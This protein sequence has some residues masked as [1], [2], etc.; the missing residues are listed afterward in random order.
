MCNPALLVADAIVTAGSGTFGA[1]NTFAVPV[2]VSGV[3][4]L[5]AYQFDLSYDPSAL[6]LLSINEGQLLQSAGSTFFIPGT[7]DNTAGTATS[8]ADSRVGMIP[9]ASGDGDLAIF[10]FK[11]LSI[12]T[13]TLTLSNMILLDSSLNPIA[14][15]TANGTSYL[16]RAG[17]K[18]S[19]RTRLDARFCISGTPHMRS[20]GRK[21]IEAV[22]NP[23]ALATMLWYGKARISWIGSHG[24]S[25]G[26]EPGARRSSRSRLVAHGKQSA[27]ARF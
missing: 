4:D 23:A 18:L 22:T 3:S 20:D 21:P 10:D 26:A 7:I 9:G 2:S 16:S 15:I 17:T 19:S 5:Y 1:G 8:I 11:A 25:D 14:F 24:L 6:Q 27:A 13:S 12:G